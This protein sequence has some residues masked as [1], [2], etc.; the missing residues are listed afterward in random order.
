MQPILARAGN[1]AGPPNLPM[2]RRTA[3]AIAPGSLSPGDAH[4][5]AVE[6]KPA[7]EGERTNA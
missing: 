6:L 4:D 3:A 1:D 7:P 2:Q 5:F